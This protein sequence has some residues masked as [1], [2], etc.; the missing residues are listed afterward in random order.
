MSRNDGSHTPLSAPHSGAV[1]LPFTAPKSRTRRWILSLCVC[2]CAV[3]GFETYQYTYGRSHPWLP[4]SEGAQSLSRAVLDDARA[5]LDQLA[6]H[7]DS[8]ALRLV[9][10]H[11]KDQLFVRHGAPGYFHPVGAH[12]S[13]DPIL[14]QAP[15]GYWHYVLRHEAGHALAL[16]H[17]YWVHTPPPQPLRL[18]LPNVHAQRL[19]HEVFADLFAL[20]IGEQ[21]TPTHPAH[22]ALMAMPYLPLEGDAWVYDTR[23]AF[24]WIRTHRADLERLSAHEQVQ[25]LAHLAAHA[26]LVQLHGQQP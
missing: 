7:Y 15:Q 26:T 1:F 17:G 21:Y 9:R 5:H 11:V 4:P 2:A 18:G 20:W 19:F 14:L 6:A 8:R 22:Q 10:L 3:L 13:I 24:H 23:G 25:L 12:L 16:E